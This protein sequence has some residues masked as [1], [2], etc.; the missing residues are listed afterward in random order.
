MTPAA[1]TKHQ[2]RVGCWKGTVPEFEEMI[3]SDKWVEATPEQIEAQR[4]EMLALVAMCKARL[5]IWEKDGYPV[6]AE[7]P[8]ET[9]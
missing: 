7:K 1:D 4:P 3:L 5:A 8:E 9:A 2:L 6:L